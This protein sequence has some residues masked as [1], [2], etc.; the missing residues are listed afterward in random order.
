MKKL[1]FILTISILV[2]GCTPTQVISH[3]PVET[4]VT[5]DYTYEKMLS[6]Q[7]E[8]AKQME[9]WSPEAIEDFKRRFIYKTVTVITPTDTIV[10]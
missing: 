4:P 1:F 8:L 9:T 2:G 10:Y 3:T 7:R 6:S 5:S